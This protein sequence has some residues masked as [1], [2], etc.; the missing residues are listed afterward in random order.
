MD[1]SE[2]ARNRPEVEV[3]VLPG[4]PALLRE[5]QAPEL[6]FAAEAL[7]ARLDDLVKEIDGVRCDDDA[8][9]VHRMRVASRRL[10]AGVKTFAD[11]FPR[12]LADG[13]RRSIRRITRDLGEAR[14]LDV[15]IDLVRQT[16]ESVSDKNFRP[17]LDRL[18]LRLGQRRA[19]TQHEVVRTIDRLVSG[20]V[21]VDM[22]EALR[23]AR[24]QARLH[25]GDGDQTGLR[26]RAAE[27]IRL[28][29]EELM[30]Y[31]LWVDRPEMS[32][33]HH[34]MRIEAKHLR[35]TLEIFEPLY[36][37]DLGAPLRIV[38]K[39]QR[40][41]GDLHDCD[42]W[43]EF[44]PDFIDEERQRMEAFLGHSRGFKR[45]AAGLKHLIEDRSKA[46]QEHYREFRGLWHETAEEEAWKELRVVAEQPMRG[47]DD[48]TET[49]APQDEKVH[50]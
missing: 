29:L 37:K 18:L 20:R 1:A 50:A 35:Y 39:L 48:G 3:E 2:T 44:L 6:L 49:R 28:N 47:P 46:R 25:A 45:I 26:R 17:G 12:K 31:D 7:L 9:H 27:A 5:R 13:W 36:G 42:V 10:R 38:K 32:S 33:E 8:E 34:Q 16:L 23:R 21:L 11:C 22:A 24:L 14:D 30:A 40:T 41:L 43:I 15:Q 19:E 4:P